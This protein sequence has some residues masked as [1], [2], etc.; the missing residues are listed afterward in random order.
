MTAIQSCLTNAF[1]IKH[2]S[3]AIM[4]EYLCATMEFE[5]AIELYVAVSQIRKSK[6]GDLHL[7]EIVKDFEF[8]TT[9]SL[10]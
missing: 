7:Q 8:D 5:F 4:S 10:G 3:F 1:C 2:L 6:Q 9:K